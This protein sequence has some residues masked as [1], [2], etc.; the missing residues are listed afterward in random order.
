MKNILLIEQNT[1]E[2]SSS[3]CDEMH[4]FITGTVAYTTTSEECYILRGSAGCRNIQR[5]YNQCFLTCSLFS[6][7]TWTGSQFNV[8]P[9]R[10]HFTEKR[11]FE[12]ITNACD[13]KLGVRTFLCLLSY[14]LKT[15]CPLLIV[16]HL[17]PHTVKQKLEKFG[18]KEELSR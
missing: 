10:Q 12:P 17:N 18:L 14:H 3:L 1:F 5:P 9:K 15:D 13:L 4:F 16:I 11:K 8:S 6:N 7:I 2:I